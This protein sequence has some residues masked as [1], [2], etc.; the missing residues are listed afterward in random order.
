M[1]ENVLFR[2]LL[3]RAEAEQPDV[4][5]ERH[6]DLGFGHRLRRLADDAGDHHGMVMGRGDGLH[7]QLEH[8]PIE[9]DLRI[10][11]RELR[12][13]HADGESARAGVEVI[14]RQRPLATFVELALRREGERMRGNDL[15][16]T[17]PF[18]R[19]G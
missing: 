15:A 8:R 7:R 1:G 6:G 11:D 17:Q 9:P 14:P 18:A 10:A 12:R 13:V 3:P 2:F 5:A 19:A 16:A 4:V